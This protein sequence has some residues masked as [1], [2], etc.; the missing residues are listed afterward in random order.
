MQWFK[1]A[2]S[3]F[4]IAILWSANATAENFPPGE[5]SEHETTVDDL[6]R[7]YRVFTPSKPRKNMPLVFVL[8]GG[9]FGDRGAKQLIDYVGMNEIAER[10]RF[11]AV[12][13]MG[14]EG[15]WND[16]RNVEFIHAHK[17]NIDDIKFLRTVVDEIA[18]SQSVDRGRIFTTGISNGAMMSHRLAAEASDLICA[19]A[20]VAGGLPKPIA[21]KFAPKHPVSLF[22][23]QGAADPLVPIGG[24]EIGY[25]IGRKRGEIISTKEAVAKYAKH[26]GNSGKIVSTKIADADPDDETT[27]KAGVFPTGHGG[28]KLQVYVV[29][30]GG[31]TWPGKKQYLNERLVG[32]TS[33][34]YNAT[35][36][37]WKFFK[38]CP[39]RK[40]S[41]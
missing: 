36:V 21:E 5:L 15:N 10:E 25:K 4:A 38:S 2:A 17:A 23:I 13:P 9:G 37:I 32:K 3:L 27:T 39:S 16:G 33:Q 22:I 18:K 40:I 24:G 6:P 28:V 8:H 14:V 29:V 35:E 11:L 34:D 41:R 7:V 12:Y 19:A 26:N 31:H 20:P 30:G 1:S